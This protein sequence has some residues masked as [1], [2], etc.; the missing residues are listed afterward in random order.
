[1][2]RVVEVLLNWRLGSWWFYEVYREARGCSIYNDLPFY[3]I[4]YPV[5]KILKRFSQIWFSWNAAAGYSSAPRSIFIYSQPTTGLDSRRSKMLLPSLVTIFLSVPV[6]SL[7]NIVPVNGWVGQRNWNA[8]TL[9]PPF[10][11][12]PSTPIRVCYAPTQRNTTR[13]NYQGFSSDYLKSPSMSVTSTQPPSIVSVAPVSSTSVPNITGISTPST[14]TIST[15]ALPTPILPTPILSNGAVKTAPCCI[16]LLSSGLIL[17]TL[18][19]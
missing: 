5:I 19:L 4:D 13:H 7:G 11:T 17:T 1:M 18:L 2:F 15:P 16:F 8:S 6:Y 12:L 14:P 10:T 3:R 9:T